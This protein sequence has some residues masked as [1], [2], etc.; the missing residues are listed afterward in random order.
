VNTFDGNVLENQFLD[1]GY[2]RSHETAKADVTVVNTCSVTA[3]AD[4]EARYLARRI[5]RENPETVIVFTGCYAQTDSA[6]LAAMDEIDFVVPNEV[7]DQLFNI[8][9]RGISAR[10][11]GETTPKMPDGISTVSENKQMHFK[12]SVTLFDRADST[13]TRAFV[14]IQD[15]CNGFC[16]YCLIPYARGASRSVDPQPVLDEITR[17]VGLGTQEVVLTGIHIGDYGEDLAH[18]NRRTGGGGRPIADLVR[19]IF[20]TTDLKRLRISSL[21]PAEL[22]DELVAALADHRSAVCDHLHLPLQSGSDRILKLMR[23]TYDRAGY[24]AAVQ[25]FRALFPDAGIG[26]DVI[27]GFP[28]E[29][30][31]DFADT[32]RLVEEL[33]LS[34]L[35]VFPYSKRP[36]TAAYKMPG[37]LDPGVVK[38]RA[39]TLR[40]LSEEL[41]RNFAGR[42]IGTDQ[43]VLWERDTDSAGRPTGY[44]RNYL[45][46]SLA[47]GH[48]VQPG[49]VTRVRIKGFV[50]QGRL[51]GR[52]LS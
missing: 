35:H 27:P 9:E 14:K 15:G 5:R 30:E 38:E 45:P 31:E 20:T 41:S 11:R 17:L 10:S 18:Y 24:G 7:K 28:G 46:V 6:A 49:Q 13:Q 19:R 36:N 26:A 44:S 12:S 3:N 42:F 43:E 8:V 16:S 33:G 32:V 37:H 47:Q 29:T 48:D 21:E 39:R 50:K 34:Y 25:K 2:S 4:R 52:P 51:L 23:R 40:V 1:H 22:S